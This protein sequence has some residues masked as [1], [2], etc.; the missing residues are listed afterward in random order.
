MKFSFLAICCLFTT[1]AVAQDFEITGT[2]K[3]SSQVS[4]EAATVYMQTVSDS[5]LVT[6]TITDR[7]GFFRLKGASKAENVNLFISYTGYRTYKKE[8]TLNKPL[9]NLGEIIL[10][11]ATNSLGEVIVTASAP[12]MLKSDTLQFN[13][14]SFNTRADA[15]LEELL[16]KLPGVE[17]DNEGNITVNGKPVNKILVNGEEFFGGDPKIATK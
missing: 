8:L 4:L 14:D 13:A 2:V 15:N 3:D 10:K 5:T 11:P 6:Y 9:I 17:V 7:D 12:V 16:K 1:L